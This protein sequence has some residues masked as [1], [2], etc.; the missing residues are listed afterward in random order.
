M[1]RIFLLTLFI[2][3]VSASRGPYITALADPACRSDCGGGQCEIEVQVQ[4]FLAAI[5][6]PLT[7]S[8]DCQT[9]EVI[10]I[11]KSGYATTYVQFI[12]PIFLFY[13]ILFLFCF[14]SASI[15]YLNTK[16]L[17]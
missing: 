13:S 9:W 14:T 4:T 5:S 8:K 16:Q 10:E 11:F 17:S 3:L 1:L 2:V 15:S 6:I 12:I 7:V